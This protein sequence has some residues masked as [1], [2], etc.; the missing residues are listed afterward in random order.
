MPHLEKC[1]LTN[2]FAFSAPSKPR[3]LRSNNRINLKAF[4]QGDSH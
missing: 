4:A 3:F 2:D 1:Q